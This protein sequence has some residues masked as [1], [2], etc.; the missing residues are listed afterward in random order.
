MGLSFNI[1]G[2][3]L[4][5]LRN[6]CSIMMLMFTTRLGI[7]VDRVVVRDHREDVADRAGR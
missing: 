3:H 1:L 4:E 6:Q 7:G 5:M 2:A